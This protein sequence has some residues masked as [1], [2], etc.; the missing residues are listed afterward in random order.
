MAFSYAKEAETLL[1]RIGNDVTLY[2]ELWTNGLMNEIRRFP[3]LV[4][5]ENGSTPPSLS[6]PFYNGDQKGAFGYRAGMS[7]ISQVNGSTLQLKHVDCFPACITV[8]L[9]S[10][11]YE[12]HKNGGN[13]KCVLLIPINENG[14]SFQALLEKVRAKLSFLS[15][16]IQKSG[17]STVPAVPMRKA[18]GAVFVPVRIQQIDIGRFYVLG[19]V[20]SGVFTKNDN[21]T[22][23]DGSKNVLQENCPIIAVSQIVNGTD[24]PVDSIRPNNGT[25]GIFTAFWFPPNTA[26]NSL[27]LVKETYSPEFEPQ[28]MPNEVKLVSEKKTGFLSRLFSK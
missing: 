16:E 2:A 12:A 24:T 23:T 1:A 15:V 18:S 9:I 13:V 28:V 10:L 20:K 27:C 7:C 21:I 3:N 5:P 25:C 19:T 14:S 11:W 8:A 26:F 4:P 6:V 22:L 17:I